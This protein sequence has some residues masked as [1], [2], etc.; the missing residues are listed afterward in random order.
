MDFFHQMHP[1]WQAALAHTKASLDNIESEL[2][3]QAFVPCHGDVMKVFR[4][5]PSAVK[6][7]IFGQD[8]YPTPGNAMGLAFSI[9]SSTAKIPASLRNIYKELESELGKAA[10]NNGDLTH[11]SEQGVFLLNRIL[12]TVPGQSLAHAN[13]GWQSFTDEV[14]KILAKLE[15]IAIFWGNRSADLSHLFA[16]EL[17]IKSPHPSPLSAYRGFFGSRPFS[18]VNH[19]LAKQNKPLIN[20]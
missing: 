2:I 19:I 17:V 6:V 16:E 9:T 13:L 20:W 15:V 8:P 10:R 11:W 5:P 7:V 4:I 18:R 1:E 12:T 3:T 14:A